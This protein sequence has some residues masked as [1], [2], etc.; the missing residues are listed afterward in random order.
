MKYN[1]RKIFLKTN[2]SLTVLTCPSIFS[3]PNVL[4]YPAVDL[5]HE[6]IQRKENHQSSTGGGRLHPDPG[7]LQETPDH[8]T[9]FLSLA[10]QN[11]Q[12]DGAGSST[13]EGG[14]A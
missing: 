12:H 9:E 8:G 7:C 4:G 2:V 1:S 10:E 11:R 14:G 13:F 3:P 6:E 5:D